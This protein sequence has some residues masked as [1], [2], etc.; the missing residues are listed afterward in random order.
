MC[1][2]NFFC[3]LQIVH[4][5]TRACCSNKSIQHMNGGFGSWNLCIRTIMQ[6]AGIGNT[7]SH[8]LESSGRSS[9]RTWSHW[10]RADGMVSVAWFIISINK[11]AGDAIDSGLTGRNNGLNF[12]VS[13]LNGP[14]SS[15]LITVN[16]FWPFTSLHDDAILVEI[17]EPITSYYIAGKIVIISI[18]IYPACTHN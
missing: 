2:R 9:E 18:I 11:L 15:V 7:L 3:D 13:L 8:C 5:H 10:T 12:P 14:L 16:K 4:N 6:T 17:T 1:V